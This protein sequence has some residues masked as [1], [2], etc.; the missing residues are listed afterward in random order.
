MEKIPT[1]LHRSVCITPQSLNSFIVRWTSDCHHV[2]PTCASICLY[3]LL[4]SLCVLVWGVSYLSTP[5]W[6]AVNAID[7]RLLCATLKECHSSWMSINTYKTPTYE[8]MK[9]CQTSLACLTWYYYSGLQCC[10][11]QVYPLVY[12]VNACSEPGSCY[13]HP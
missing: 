13:S 7:A 10:I 9:E 11:S 8:F 4:H 3:S 1:Q 6:K 5:W 12:S 2:F